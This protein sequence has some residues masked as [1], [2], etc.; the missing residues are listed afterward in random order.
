MRL[1]VDET[2]VK[3]VPL[4][5]D[6]A[7]DP[8]RRRRV[9]GGLHFDAPIKM[10]RALAKLEIAK[11]L[12]RQRPERRAFFGKHH[13]DLAFRGAMDPRVRPVLLPAIR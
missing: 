6:A 3:V 8:A 7:P 9:K 13:G 5:M 4:H 11:R 10:D 12:D 2:D 1:R